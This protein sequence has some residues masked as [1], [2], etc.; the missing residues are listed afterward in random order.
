MHIEFVGN[1]ANI[2]SAKHFNGAL[3][4]DMMKVLVKK[5]V[6]N[7]THVGKSDRANGSH[8]VARIIWGDYNGKT[9]AVVADGE[10]IKKNKITVISFYDVHNKEI[11]AKRFNMKEIKS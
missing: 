6:T 7:A 3:T 8:T 4:E 1:K 9:Y 5:I 2:A 10:D 11:K